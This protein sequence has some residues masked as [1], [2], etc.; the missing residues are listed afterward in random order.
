[1]STAV[2]QGPG[3]AEGMGFMPPMASSSVMVPGPSPSH[4]DNPLEGLDNC[5]EVLHL[6]VDGLSWKSKRTFTPASATMYCQI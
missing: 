5:G 3:C 4:E 2:S 6:F 1:M